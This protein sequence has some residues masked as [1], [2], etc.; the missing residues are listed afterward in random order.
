MMTTKY[1]E[2]PYRELEPVQH[3]YL[4]FRQHGF[5][6]FPEQ[7]KIYRNIAITLN[8]ERIIEI[9]AGC[10]AGAAIMSRH[11]KVL[12]TEVNEDAVKWIG[13]FY[14]WLYPKAFDIEKNCVKDFG[15]VIV[16]IEVFE[17]L[18]N[19]GKAMNNLLGSDA[20]EIW[21]STPN[22]NNPN[23]GQ[24]KPIN[25]YHV[26]EFTPNEILAMTKMGELWKVQVIHWNTWD[27]I[28]DM[29]TEVTPLVYRLFK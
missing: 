18:A 17:H 12:P 26:R 7:L 21:L 25:D 8:A 10:G 3:N 20:K 5:A 11:N 15:G 13:A 19:W 28:E 9:G 4:K 24:D 27:I 6:L 1:K 16:M 23:L 22:R 2:N 29:D 14:P